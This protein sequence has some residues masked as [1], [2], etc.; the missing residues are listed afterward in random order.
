MIESSRSGSIDKAVEALPRQRG[1]S[2]RGHRASPG[3]NYRLIREA[4]SSCIDRYDLSTL[5][6]ERIIVALS[7]GKDSL[8][9]ARC[10]ID[11]GAD[12]IPITI[13]MGYERGWANRIKAFASA[14]GVTPRI[15]DVRGQT[16]SSNLVDLQISRRMEKLDS[17]PMSGASDATPCTHCYS[18]KVLAL[19][20][21]ARREGVTKVAFAHHMTDAIASLVKEGLM[22][23]DRQLFRHSQYIRTNF[24]LLVDQLRAEAERPPD[25]LGPESLTN[26][27]AALVEDCNVDTDE[28]PRQP[29]RVDESQCEIIRPMF[30]VDESQIR[31]VVADMGLQTADSGCGH[32]ATAS[33]QTPREIV[34]FRLLNE[35]SDTAYYQLLKGLVL[36]GI[37]DDGTGKVRARQ[38]R[39]ELLGPYYK[40]PADDLD[41]L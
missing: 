19:D 8:L 27:L 39:S 25:K 34:H 9:L 29:L 20:S 17:I 31:R 24:E 11:L 32:G 22:H 6:S 5:S 41:K 30:L 15:L 14:I 21:T 12:V 40:P 37:S 2:R 3:E 28:P 1:N 35:L 23:L 26:S 7:G 13:D 38:R 4:V 33:T 18:V 10:L 16:G 36:R